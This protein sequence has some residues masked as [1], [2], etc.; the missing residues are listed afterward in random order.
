MA[1]KKIVS[2]AIAAIAGQL[3]AGTYTW[4]GEGNDGKWFTREN[5]KYDDGAGN[6]TNPAA[7]APKNNCSDDITIDGP[8]AVAYEPGGD[9]K[10]SG[11]LT[12]ING[13]SFEQTTGT[14]YCDVKGGTIYLASG[15][16]FDSG[17]MTGSNG[18]GLSNV[19]V[20]DGGILYCRRDLKRSKFEVRRGGRLELTVDSYK[21]P[22]TDDIQEGGILIVSGNISPQAEASIS[23]KGTIQAT[24]QFKPASGSEFANAHVICTHAALSG[25]VSL[26]S[27]T[28]T[29]TDSTSGGLSS[30]GSTTT[31]F[32]FPAGSTCRLTIS[33]S[34]DT[35]YSQTF[36]TST[37]KP[38]YR[39]DG[40]P[41]SQ[42]QFE[43][44]FETA[45]NGDGTVSFWPRAISEDAPEVATGAVTI[46]STDGS[47]L[48][49]ATFSKIGDPAAQVYLVYGAED[50]GRKFTDWGENKILLGTASASGLSGV[51]A[52]GLPA[53]QMLFFR[54]FAVNEEGSSA[55]DSTR[56]Y[57]R[58]Y[59][60]DGVVNEWIGTEGNWTDGTQWS[61][62]HQPTD[63]EIRWIEKADAVVTKNNYTLNDTDHMVAGTLALT[64]E[65]YSDVDY[66]LDG[67]N[68]SCTTFV[69]SGNK[70]TIKNGSLT[71]YR[72][73]APSRQKAAFMAMVPESTSFLAARLRCDSTL[74]ERSSPTPLEAIVSSLMDSKL[75][76]LSST[77]VSRTRR[78]MVFRKLSEATTLITPTAST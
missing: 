39:Y 70:F 69:P 35:L 30:A 41:I 77:S 66:V 42:E 14:A 6:V 72:S 56:L 2:I 3:F 28:I 12:L 57:T 73:G 15:G 27:G 29:C 74:L 5:W 21:F 53:R 54:V 17:T 32:N 40:D 46:G 48:V 31:Y 63:S 38:K 25:A 45:D 19:I 11:T 61:L 59:G 9:L 23:S 55:S 68:F 36:G 60:V 8:S 44:L 26:L 64:G 67:F 10:I 47:V 16:S 24:G 49:S 62:G 34:V 33:G 50:K 43:T 20:D 58:N 22:A 76:R 52:S 13:A 7:A 78:L 1:V 4:T 75:T 18:V 71:S 65:L 51:A 37:T